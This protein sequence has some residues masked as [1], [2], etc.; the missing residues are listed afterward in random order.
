M[1]LTKDMNT[2]TAAPR[3]EHYLNEA[4]IAE[5]LGNKPLANVYLQYAERM[6]ELIESY[7]NK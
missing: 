6:E 2:Q 5:G 7:K 1:L 4:A 3:M